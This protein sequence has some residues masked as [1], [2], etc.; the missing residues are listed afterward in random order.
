MRYSVHKTCTTVFTWH[1]MRYSVLPWH[2]L[3]CSHDM[4]CTV[5]ILPCVACSQWKL[6]KTRCSYLCLPLLS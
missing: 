4:I 5:W 1:D 6:F 3:Q 2:A